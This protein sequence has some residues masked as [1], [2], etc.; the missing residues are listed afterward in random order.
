MEL[1]SEH[2]GVG[3]RWIGRKLSV[4]WQKYVFDIIVTLT[5]DMMLQ[6]SNGLVLGWWQTIPENFMQFGQLDFDLFVTLTF[7]FDLIAPKI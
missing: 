2:F 1:K 7:T 4:L 5:F 6:Q 3:F